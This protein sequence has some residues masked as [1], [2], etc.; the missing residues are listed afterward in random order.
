MEYDLNVI[1]MK[2]VTR[3]IDLTNLPERFKNGAVRNRFHVES[4]NGVNY[5]LVNR[6][7]LSGKEC[8]PQLRLRFGSSLLD[9]I[10][11]NEVDVTMIEDQL[12]I[13]LPEE[14][15]FE[16][17]NQYLDEIVISDRKKIELMRAPR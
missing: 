12:G 15:D 16:R 10:T 4:I 6:S 17:I 1:V 9:D 14:L 3:S 5:I 7:S 13:R 11:L 2:M 8:I